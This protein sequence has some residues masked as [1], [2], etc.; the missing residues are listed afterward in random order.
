MYRDVKA[1]MHPPTPTPHN[2]LKSLIDNQSITPML[3]VN[4]NLCSRSK[5]MVGL[6]AILVHS[7]FEP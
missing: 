2:I 6:V 5:S 4:Y 1:A 3:G 7:P